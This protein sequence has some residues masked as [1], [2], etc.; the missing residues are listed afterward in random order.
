MI[1]KAII[2][3]S[4]IAGLASS[5]RLACKGYEVHVY[6]KNAYPG[7]K[8]T[9][10]EKDGYR[11]DAGPSIFTLPHLVDELFTLAGKN[12]NDYFQYQKLDVTARY[13][14]EDG[15]QLTAFANSAKLIK[16]IECK[17]NANGDEV[18]K[19]LA[20]VER[21]FKLSYPVFVE[22][23]LN[24]LSSFLNKETVLA[25]INIR[26]FNLFTS[27]HKHN[28][29][30]FSNPKLVQMWDRY[31]SYN[32][33]NAYSAPGVLS[34]ISNLEHNSGVFLPKG[35]IHS[36]TKSLHQ[37]GKDIGVT[38][39]FNKRID[40][41]EVLNKTITSISVDG[42]SLTADVFVSNVD[43]VSLYSMIDGIKKPTKPLKLE[44]SSSALIFYWG[45]SK[46]FDNLG[47]H[48]VLFSDDYKEEFRNIFE[49]NDIYIDPTIYINIT[50]KKE[51]NDAPVGCENWF[52]MINV[53]SNFNQDWD[54]LIPKFREIIKN[55]ISRI[56]KVDIDKH[57]VLEEI[58][59]PIKI[60][61]KTLSHRGS[62]YGAASNSNMAIF[63]RHPNST[64]R[65]KNLYFVGGSVHPGGGMPICLNSAKI[66]GKMIK[67]CNA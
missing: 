28:K 23:P 46:L 57:I 53:P 22:K 38:Y 49:L 24:K 40:K 66:V 52:T 9:F 43:I 31:A 45:V 58:L 65:F 3:G 12:T 36:I 50:S 2:I 55:K 39:H 37:L 41:I 4:G 13:F 5:I 42:S 64:K 19:Y 47:V 18:E 67:D 48:N 11:F 21:L 26:K 8:L 20:E 59:D 30:S 14:W 61:E 60:E 25:I 62:I 10:L 54:E 44:R 16:E 15:T 17:L 6:E 7:G 56:L 35:G 34:V 32:G 33:S 51:K 27:L 1:K 29:K 63:H